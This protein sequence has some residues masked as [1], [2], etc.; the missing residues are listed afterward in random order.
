MDASKIEEFIGDQLTWKLADL[1]ARQAFTQT[2]IGMEY[3]KAET[4]SRWT[5][6]HIG[7][8]HAR[9]YSNNL[10]N[11]RLA[12]SIKQSGGQNAQ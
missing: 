11:K 8:V 6:F 12:E 3:T 10:D 5:F 4:L 7:W 2:L 1:A 9:L